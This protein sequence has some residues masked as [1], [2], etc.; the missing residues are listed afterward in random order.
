MPRYTVSRAQIGHQLASLLEQ[1]DRLDEAEQLHMAALG[2]QRSLASQFPGTLYHTVRL[3]EFSND[4]ARLLLLRHRPEEARPVLESA[5]AVLTPALK[6]NQDLRVIHALLARSYG[7]L[8]AT[9]RDLGN[10]PAAAQAR[11]KA[12]EHR[13]AMLS[14]G[15]S[16]AGGS[17]L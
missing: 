12:D 9:F 15:H 14:A 4:L 11:Q 5:V 13:K 7:A 16:A 1:G 17:G 2:L 3:G 10:E 6:G 8:E